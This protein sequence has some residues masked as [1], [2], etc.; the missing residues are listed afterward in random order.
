MALTWKVQCSVI[1]YACPPYP[2]SCVTVLGRFRVGGRTIRDGLRHLVDRVDRRDLSI[3]QIGL[4][5]IEGRSTNALPFRIPSNLTCDSK[6]SGARQISN[7]TQNTKQNYWRLMLKRDKIIETLA[8]VNDPELHRSL[9]DLK[10]VRDV[11]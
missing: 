2:G 7:V 8:Q 3:F 10:M 6:L 9:T 5:F 11:G 4:R 1:F